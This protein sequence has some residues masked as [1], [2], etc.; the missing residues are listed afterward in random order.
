[1]HIIIVAEKTLAYFLARTFQAKDH[2]VTIINRNREDC[3]WLARRSSAT[4]VF[5]DGSNPK[6]LRD[7]G[8]ETADAVLAAAT[9]DED[10]LVICQMADLKF[11]VPRV[12]SVVND[13]DN[14]Q[15]FR[16]LGVSDVFP[17]TLLLSSL[18]EQRVNSVGISS[19][20]PVAEGKITVS[21][22]RLNEN[23]PAAGKNM[24]EIKMPE[25]SLVACIVRENEAIVPRGTTVISPSDRLIVMSVPE[26]H[27]AAMEALTGNGRA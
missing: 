8:A 9:R 3:A 11:H 2:K 25:N 15:V 10:N 12:I 20:I 13:P 4:V 23:S 7:A 18:I 21:E 24:S 22:V 26:N 14:E 27:Q 17:I 1:M 5:G 6:V 16:Q 19:L